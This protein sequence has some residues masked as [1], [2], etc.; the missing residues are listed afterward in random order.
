MLFCLVD[1]CLLLLI[2]P[3]NYPDTFY[4]IPLVILFRNIWKLQ[5][6]PLNPIQLYTHQLSC[7]GPTRSLSSCNIALHKYE[8]QIRPFNWWLDGVVV[9]I[10]GRKLGDPGS[11][12]GRALNLLNSYLNS[13]ALLLSWQVFPPIDFPF[14]NTVI[15]ILW[16]RWKNISPNFW[17][18]VFMLMLWTFFKEN[19][20]MLPSYL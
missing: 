18:V 10:P 20:L 16:Q 11:I 6:A 7:V 9:S 2:F 4:W 12:P 15:E 8:F 19:L 1:K 13:Y 14:N 17:K 5:L 3:S